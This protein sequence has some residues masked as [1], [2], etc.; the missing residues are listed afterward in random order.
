VRRVRL[1]GRVIWDAATRR[2]RPFLTH[3]AIRRGGN[4]VFEMCAAK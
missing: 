1:D 3:K 2:G 4:L